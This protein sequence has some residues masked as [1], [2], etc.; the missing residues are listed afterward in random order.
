MSA[1]AVQ[2]EQLNKMVYRSNPGPI[3]E[4]FRYIRSGVDTE[5]NRLV[6]TVFI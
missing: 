6:L 5:S 4:A 3:E 1:Y 2:V